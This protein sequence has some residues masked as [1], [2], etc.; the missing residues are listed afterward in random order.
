MEK[1]RQTPEVKNATSNRKKVMNPKAKPKKNGNGMGWGSK[2]LSFWSWLAVLFMWACAASIHLSPNVWGKYLSL[3]GLSFPAGLAAVAATA[4]ACLLFKPKL[5]FIHLLGVACCFSAVRD[6]CPVN[7]SSPPPK[8]AL[9][10]LSYNTEGIGSHKLDGLD[11]EAVR[12]V[13]SQEADFIAMQEMNYRKAKDDSLNVERT[14]KR[15]GYH[16]LHHIVY[17]NSLALASKWPITGVESICGSKHNGVAAFFVTPKPG[18][19]VI[20]INAHLESMHLSNKQRQ[21]FHSMVK[22]PEEADT[23]KGK[24]ALI[25]QI[26]QSSTQRALQADTLADYITRHKGHKILLMG[27]FNN[28][29]ISYAHHRIC[30]LLT[31]CYKAA[32]NGI[33]R[34]F[35][36]DAIYVRI[37]NIFCSS[38]YKPYTTRVDNSVPFSDHYPIITYL[39]EVAPEGKRH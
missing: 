5:L 7:L 4:L 13:C 26:A 36:K 20:V 2:F 1:D 31:D 6:Y 30:S 35:N 17:N 38:H 9:K 19:T 28:T 32:G 39:K 12:Y 3:L 11:F 14:M 34:S 37:D 21:S 29:P 24:L 18:D 25:K 15:Y 22:N 16:Y 27:D 10:L 8:G 33:G 23:I